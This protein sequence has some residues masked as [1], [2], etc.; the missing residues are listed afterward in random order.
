MPKGELQKYFIMETHD[1]QWARHLG[2]ERTLALV[3]QTYY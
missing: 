3:S 1:P 2:R